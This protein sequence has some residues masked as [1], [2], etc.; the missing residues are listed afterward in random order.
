[1]KK[2]LRKIIE[3]T[4]TLASIGIESI[5]RVHNEHG[6]P[7]TKKQLS[8]CI[9]GVVES[10]MVEV[11][12]RYGIQIEAPKV[13]SKPDTIINYK[14][15]EIKTIA[16]S[17][18]AWRGGAYSKRESDYLFIKWDYSDGEF[19]WFALHKYLKE[20]DWIGCDVENKDNNYYATKIRLNEML[21]GEILVGGKEKKRVLYHPVL[22]T[23]N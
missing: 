21:D 3:P 11:A 10:K 15:L 13:D 18:D 9:S 16:A 23:L 20:D 14:P 22:Q 8:E 1:M 12:K 17:S 2:T 7:M 4:L 6:N 5:M 19:T